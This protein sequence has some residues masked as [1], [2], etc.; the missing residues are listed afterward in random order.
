MLQTA[1]EPSASSA[2][3]RGWKSICPGC[4]CNL[5]P[6]NQWHAHWPP[7]RA[8]GQR[9]RHLGLF[10]LDCIYCSWAY[11][12]IRAG[13][14]MP[15]VFVWVITWFMCFHMLLELSLFGNLSSRC[16]HLTMSVCIRTSTCPCYNSGSY[17]I[18]VGSV[19]F[20]ISRGLWTWA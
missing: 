15:L 13:F 20:R 14:G 2:V 1:K 9:R 5:R 16:E 7:L 19:A 8:S 4:E 6:V 17:S 12:Y 3:P 18:G 11:K 10:K